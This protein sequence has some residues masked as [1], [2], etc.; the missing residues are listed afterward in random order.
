MYVVCSLSLNVNNRTPLPY[1]M[2]NYLLG[3][4]NIH[5]KDFVCGNVAL[6]LRSITYP[7]LGMSISKLSQTANRS[8]SFSSEPLSL[9]MFI[10]GVLLLTG[11]SI[12]FAF[13]AKQELKRMERDLEMTRSTDAALQQADSTAVV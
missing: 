11:S 6:I 10:V 3:S 13:K 1:V 5:L 9:T 2:G 7:V 4:T 12:V 8:Q